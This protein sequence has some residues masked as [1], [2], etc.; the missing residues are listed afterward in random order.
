MC[1]IIDAD[2]S[3]EIAA[4]VA[5]V[6]ALAFRDWMLA[7]PCCLVVGGSRL[8]AEFGRNFGDL[9]R[10][11]STTVTEWLLQV[12]LAGKL[13]EHDDDEV[14]VRAGEVERAGLCASND[15]HIIA[16][17]QVASARMLYS[18]DRELQQDFTNP[19]LLDRPRGKVYPRN[20]SLSASKRWLDR[21]RRLCG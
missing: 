15:F 9:E 2:S 13:I 7:G 10:A 8:R 5:S 1:T 18:R 4:G 16:L 11:K 6:G 3:G 17:A 21:H 14:D 12:S 19:A 20:R